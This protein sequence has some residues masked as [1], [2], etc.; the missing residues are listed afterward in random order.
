ME[1]KKWEVVMGKETFSTIQR[2]VT[3]QTCSHLQP[4]QFFLLIQ[5]WRGGGGRGR[6]I[7]RRGEKGKAQLELK[8]GPS[9]SFQG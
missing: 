4:P 9:E 7:K 1:G 6:G 3:K 8:M 5:M 2:G